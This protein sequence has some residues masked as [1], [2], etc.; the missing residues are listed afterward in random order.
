MAGGRSRV[1]GRPSHHG[2]DSVKLVPLVRSESADVHA[3]HFR[4]EAFRLHYGHAAHLSQPDAV[5][6][7]G[8]AHRTTPVGS[9]VSPA[10]TAALVPPSVS[11]QRGKVCLSF[12]LAFLWQSAEIIGN[13]HFVFTAARASLSEDRGAC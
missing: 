8:A 11:A 7:P 10:G 13:F 2:A 9:P 3:Q 5:H 6:L 1:P 4:C 12:L